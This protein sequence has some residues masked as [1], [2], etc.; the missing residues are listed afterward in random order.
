MPPASLCLAPQLLGTSWLRTW[1]NAYSSKVRDR[2]THFS[3]S[4][5]DGSPS[6]HPIFS[7]LSLLDSHVPFEVLRGVL[8]SFHQSANARTHGVGSPSL[9]FPFDSLHAAELP[10]YRQF[11]CDFVL[12]N[13]FLQLPVT[14]FL[15][16][17]TFT[18]T[19]HGWSVGTFISLGIRAVFEF[20]GFL[21]RIIYNEEFLV[22]INTGR[23]W[24]V[25][26]ST[27]FEHVGRRDG[28]SDLLGALGALGN[29]AKGGNAGG[30]KG[31]ANDKTVTVTQ[32][33][34]AQAKT[35]TVTKSAAA[36]LGTGSNG[37]N[38][39]GTCAAEKTVTIEKTVTVNQAAGGTGNAGAAG[40]QLS[41]VTMTVFGSGAPPTVT[42]TPLPQQ[43]TQQVTVTVNNAAAGAS[44]AGV[45]PPAGAAAGTGGSKTAGIVKTSDPAT[46]ETASVGAAAPA[47]VSPPAG[48]AAGTGGS[49]TA[50]IVKTSN[51]AAGNTPAVGAAPAV[52][53]PGALA[54][55]T[56]TIAPGGGCNC[57]CLCGEGSFPNMGAMGGAPAAAGTTLSTV[58][59]PAA[60]NSATLS[61]AAIVKTSAGGAGAAGA[62]AAPAVSSVATSAA[63]QP[64]A[65]NSATLSSAAIVKTTAP[66]ASA[67]AAQAGTSAASSLVLSVS[68]AAGAAAQVAKPSSDPIDISTFS[69]TSSLVLGSLATPSVKVKAK[70]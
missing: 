12:L 22:C 42:V 18:S 36:A 9:T 30:A 49:K 52:G 40:L 16:S 8:H 68:G 63:V 3:N 11:S 53:S 61:S 6:S 37:S 65:V 69:L 20:Y 13:L 41:F 7:L 56:G 45:S 70:P 21:I 31:A 48:A 66:A 51:P 50:G 44:V 55:G 60:I 1:R 35:A 28:L 33:A 24:R 14:L 27:V 62:S 43:I 10:S 5:G 29:G 23:C 2:I 4:S 46:G 47:G 59:S 57:Q 19:H 34:Q 15:P 58:A 32:A 67:A 39:N 38:K 64:A 54:S 25:V 26:S 17:K